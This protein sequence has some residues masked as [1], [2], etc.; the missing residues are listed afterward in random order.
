MQA[1]RA[2]GIRSGNGFSLDASIWIDASQKRRVHIDGKVFTAGLGPRRLVGTKRDITA[3][4]AAWREARNLPGH[5]AVTGL[6]GTFA[7]LQQNGLH[8]DGRLETP[9]LRI[10]L[11]GLG[12]MRRDVPL[13]GTDEVL[14]CSADRIRHLIE[15]L[16][17]ACVPDSGSFL[18]LIKPEAAHLLSRI[19]TR[20]A[21][22]LREPIFWKNRLIFPEFF[23]ERSSW[24]P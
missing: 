8:A 14:K 1:V 18:V 17:T 24:R 16:G 10:T 7:A 11:E 12:A 23:V 21:T 3:L 15:A 5:D 13:A 2:Y 9:C 19:G 22:A 4:H 6:P 20:L